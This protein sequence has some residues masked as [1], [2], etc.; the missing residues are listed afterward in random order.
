MRR[1]ASEIIRNLEKRIAKLENK[2]ATW[3]PSINGRLLDDRNLANLREEI[4]DSSLTGEEKK[5][6]LL[7]FDKSV[8][9]YKAFRLHQQA[10]PIKTNKSVVHGALRNN[11]FDKNIELLISEFGG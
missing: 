7:A 8:L 3:F 10:N 9:R 4:E 6:L 1:S 5:Q 2:R 11:E